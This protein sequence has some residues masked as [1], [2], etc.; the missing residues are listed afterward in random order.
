[1]KVENAI[2][3][4]NYRGILFVL[5]QFKNITKTHLRFL[6]LENHNVRIFSKNGRY[7]DDGKRIKAS[8]GKFFDVNY[9]E[10]HDSFRDAFYYG[11]ILTPRIKIKS[12]DNYLSKIV[13]DLRNTTPFP[14]VNRIKIKG[15]KATYE[16]TSEGKR[17]FVEYLLFWLIKNYA[18]PTK[19]IEKM[20][21]LMIM[22]HYEVMRDSSIPLTQGESTIK[23]K[24]IRIKKNKK[25]SSPC[26]CV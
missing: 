7:T 2:K 18:V 25:S 11:E 14:L 15:K 26:E 9:N 23:L 12:A 21:E 17:L 19:G 8:F 10:K 3:N 4:D 20:I 5:Y 16:L 22:E 1:M 6:F 24:V 13:R